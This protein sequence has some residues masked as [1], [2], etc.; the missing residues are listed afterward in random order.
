MERER[1]GTEARDEGKGGRDE[2]MEGGEINRQGNGTK[3]RD[4]GKGW[5]KVTNN[6]DKRK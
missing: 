2:N 4:K 5:T 6:R 3:E 1:K